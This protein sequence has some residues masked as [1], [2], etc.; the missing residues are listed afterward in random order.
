[1]PRYYDNPLQM[2]H[3]LVARA[4]D[5]PGTQRERLSEFTQTNA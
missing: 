5:F 2:M 4:S 3:A 1:M